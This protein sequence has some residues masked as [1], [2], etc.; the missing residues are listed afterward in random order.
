MFT[1]IA[2]M[3]PFKTKLVSLFFFLSWEMAE[4]CFIWCAH[5]SK[6][7]KRHVF[8]QTGF[9]NIKLNTLVFGFCERKQVIKFQ[10]VYFPNSSKGEKASITLCTYVHMLGTQCWKA[11]HEGR[12]RRP[13]LSE[14]PRSTHWR[15]EG[16]LE[17]FACQ[18][19]SHTAENMLDLSRNFKNVHII[20]FWMPQ[21]V[22]FG[23]WH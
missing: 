11:H 1:F 8:S 17:D 23:K 6:I 4:R 20:T 5:M 15:P 3:W 10:A 22:F 14:I 19:T 16:Q 13:S 9:P 18:L 21:K 12:K 7:H 2:G